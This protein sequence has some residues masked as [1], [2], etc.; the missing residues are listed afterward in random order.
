MAPSAADIPNGGMDVTDE[1]RERGRTSIGK[2]A[3]WAELAEIDTAA[4]R[5]QSELQKI[6]DA[7]NAA[8]TELVG[9]HDWLCFGEFGACRPHKS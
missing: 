9:A 3:F 4:A 6:A 5:L 8:L 7:L 1:G 2:A